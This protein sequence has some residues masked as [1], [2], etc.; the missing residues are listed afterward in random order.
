MIE[1]KKRNK[2]KK[3]EEEGGEGIEGEEEGEEEEEEK[4]KSA[5]EQILNCR[6][7]SSISTVSSCSAVT[8]CVLW[9]VLHVTLLVCGDTLLVEGSDWAMFPLKL[10]V[11]QYLSVMCIDAVSKLPAV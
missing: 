2:K 4:E 7:P 8:S 11:K 1:K 5:V 10:R 6:N 3:E 9:D